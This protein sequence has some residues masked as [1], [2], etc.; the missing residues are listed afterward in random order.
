MEF[1][2][3]GSMVMKRISFKVQKSV[4]PKQQVGGYTPWNFG[5]TKMAPENGWLG[6]YPFLLGQNGL[7]SGANYSF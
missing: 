7:L 5:K 1:N 6:D 2:Q 3:K 4:P